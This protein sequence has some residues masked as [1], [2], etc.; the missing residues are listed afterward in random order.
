M[1]SSRPA[2]FADDATLVRH[3]LRNEPRAIRALVEQANAERLN[4]NPRQVEP[5]QLVELLDRYLR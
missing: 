2:E 4:N 1:N 5:E 3:C